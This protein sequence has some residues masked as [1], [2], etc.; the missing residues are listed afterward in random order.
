MASHRDESVKRDGF[1]SQY[2]RFTAH[3][4]ERIDGSVLQR[5]FVPKVTREGQRELY[6]HGPSFIRSQ[7]KHYGIKFDEAEF[8]GNGT[9]LMRK[10]LLAGH[11]DKVPDHITALQRQ[12]HT[13]WLETQTPQQLATNPSWVMEKY[14]LRSGQPDR[15]KTA[16]V[17]G[18][19]FEPS[20]EYRSGC[21]VE[22][23]SKVPGLHCAT[24]YGPKTQ[25]VF[26]GWKSAAVKKA[27]NEHPAKEKKEVQALKQEHEDGRAAKH[28]AYLEALKEK[29]GPKKYSPVG[30]YMIDC[31]EITDNWPDDAKNMTLN[32]RTTEERGVYEAKFDFGMFIG[33]MVICDN[34]A[35]LVQYCAELDR[36]AESRWSDGSMGFG[37]G[38]DADADIGNKSASSSKRKA[39]EAP[40]GR[41]RP[42]KQAKS[43]ENQKAQ[44]RT[45]YLRLKGRETGEGQIYPDA[46]K[47]AIKFK[48]ER[49]A[50]FLGKASLPFEGE[51]I[52]FTGRKISDQPSP[53]ARGGEWED[54]SDRAEGYARRQRWG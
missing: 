13:E 25:V 29:R 23:A 44:P 22:A 19:P 20:S 5:M 42:P 49:M 40:R 12:M 24:G 21:M 43:A 53:K 50:S 1:A 7:L 39:P 34:K 27:A 46:E 47:G 28:S 52:P 35:T 41:G 3:D 33:A 32:I 9:V 51:N 2:G 10:T 26:M 31:E 4:I 45:F 48:D 30:S 36:E 8:S 6:R 18:I 16:T 38:D 17:V 15:T 14:F 54:Y 37:D 11:C